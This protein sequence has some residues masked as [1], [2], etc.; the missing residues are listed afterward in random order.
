MRISNGL[1]VS[2]EIMVG[3]TTMFSDRGYGSELCGERALGQGKG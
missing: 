2:V 1:R 3:I